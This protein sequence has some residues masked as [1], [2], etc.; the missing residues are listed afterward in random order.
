[1][2]AF[3]K[4]EGSFGRNIHAHRSSNTCKAEVN[5]P[6]MT[7]FSFRISFQS[8]WKLRHFGSTAAPRYSLP[9]NGATRAEMAAPQPQFFN[10]AISA[11]ACAVMFHYSNTSS[12]LFLFGAQLKF[13]HRV[14]HNSRTNSNRTST[15]PP[16][17]PVR[18]RKLKG[19]HF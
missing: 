11:R 10:D 14:E 17:A 15:P 5:K 16:W 19:S 2:L 4:R 7:G 9:P 12:R 18:A 8:T 3:G 6:H 1:M 13:G